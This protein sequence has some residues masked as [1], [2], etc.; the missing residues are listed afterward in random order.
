MHTVISESIN[1]MLLFPNIYD[2]SMTNE[3]VEPSE[4]IPV[5]LLQL[6]IKSANNLKETWMWTS[7]PYVEIVTGDVVV[8]KT[9]VI[10]KNLNPWWNNETFDILVYDKP[11]QIIRMNVL[12]HETLI[13]P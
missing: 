13:L 7:D 3:E 11:T 1:S 5:G 4:V 12:H 10:Y 9:N 8:G 2:I 6:K